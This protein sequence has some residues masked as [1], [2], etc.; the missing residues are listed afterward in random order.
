MKLH[1]KWLSGLLSL[2]MVLS[3]GTVVTAA[4]TAASATEVCAAG[5][6]VNA[7]SAKIYI[8][9][10]WEEEFLTIPADYPQSFQITASGASNISYSVS[11][12]N[13]QVSADGLVTPRFT[14]YY[15]YNMGTYSVG[16]SYPLEGQEPYRV[17]KQITPGTYTARARSGND[18]AEITIELID[19]GTEY[20]NHVMDQYVEENITSAMTTEQKLDKIA[21]FVADRSYDVHYSS[22]SGLIIAGG[23]DCW[24]STDTIIRL[25]ER[26]GLEA[27]VRNGN[28]DPG[29]GS[30]H[31]NA[32]VYD[33]K[34]YYEIEAGYVGTAPRGYD[35][36]K[37]T[38]LFSIKYNSTYS[39]YEVYQYDGKVTPKTLYIPSSID[40]KTI[41]GLGDK[42]VEMDKD[43]E[44]VILPT[45]IRH[46]G[47]SAFN[48]CTNLKTI[49][50]PPSV[51][52]IDTFAFTACDSLTSV[53]ASGP[54]TFKN[55]A[56]YQ[57]GKILV[58]APNASEVTIANGVTEIADYAFYYNKNIASLTLPA[59]VTTIGEGAFGNCPA[60]TSVSINGK[61]LTTIGDF[62]FAQCS[63]L[64]YVILP[65]SVSSIGENISYLSNAGF[66]LMAPKGSYTETYA[67]EHQ[68][69]F[70]A[71]DGSKAYSISLSPSA[72]ELTA[73]EKHRL[74][75]AMI[76]A[77]VNDTVR[78]ESSNPSVASVSDGTVTAVKT[79]TA[80]ITVTTSEGKTAECTVTVKAQPLTNR[81][82]LSAGKLTLGESLTVRTASSGGSGACTYAVYYKK[83]SSDSYSLVRGFTDVSAVTLTPQSAT[84]YKV[85]VVAK[86]ADGTKARRVFTVKVYKPLLNNSVLSADTLK[87][88][89]K[90]KVRCRASGGDGSYTY[91]VYYRKAGSDKWITAQKYDANNLVIIKPGAAVKYEICIKVKDGRGTMTKKY[92]TLPVK[93]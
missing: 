33:G 62:A 35:I 40:G 47:Q 44:Q 84:E 91:A 86:D 80:V 51:Q 39:G 31:K 32:M 34:S 52:Q 66:T 43:V 14:T 13:L 81:S 65:D 83:K 92:I 55:G 88:G 22:A 54:Y 67:T 46:I 26:C 68:L 70:Y 85:L 1:R 4:V 25:A 58:A 41:V 77:G 23:G 16:Y 74:S 53:S 15:W 63:S 69:P 73:G 24:A 18:V 87:L 10:G 42:F 93:K 19:Y 29:A 8:L 49:N 82:T 79:G 60:L 6:S 12:S 37:R 76:P 28:R 57:N 56:L 89:E 45:T 30:G 71:T 9:S 7:T 75:T 50:I 61:G 48:S 17:D 3:S 20:C 21:R 38:S 64:P 36:T 11:N 5:L 27:W 2:T 78:W 72:L 90:V 59:S